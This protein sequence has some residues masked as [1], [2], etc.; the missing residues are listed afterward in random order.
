MRKIYVNFSSALVLVTSS[1]LSMGSIASSVGPASPR[2]H[3]SAKVATASVVSRQHVDARR[4]RLLDQAARSDTQTPDFET[5][6]SET[7]SVKA[8]LLQKAASSLKYPAGTSVWTSPSG[9]PA[10]S[11]NFIGQYQGSVRPDMA[12]AAGPQFVLQAVNESITLLDTSGRRQPGWPKPAQSL[13]GIPPDCTGRPAFVYDPRAFYD[14]TDSRYWV[15]IMQLEGIPGAR[16]ACP[17]V[18]QFWLAVSS[19]SDPTG[20]WNVLSFDMS[21]GTGNYADFS[22]L[23]FDGQAVY[24]SANMRNV[25]TFQYAE[26][27]EANKNAMENNQPFTALGFTRLQA[28]SVRCVMVDTV[29]PALSESQ[30]RYDPRAEFL[31]NTFNL[32][33]DPSGNDCVYSACS[34]AAVWAFS[35]PIAHDTGGSAPVLTSTLISTNPYIMPP[36]ADQPGCVRCIPTMD[37]R[38]TATPVYH[39]GLLS[40]SWST[41]INNGTQNV[42]GIAW[43]QTR[44]SLTDGSCSGSSVCPAID[45]SSTLMQQ[46]GYYFYSGDGAAYYSALMPDVGGNLFMVFDFSS[47]AFPPGVATVSR[48]ATFA[49]GAFHDGGTYLKAGAAPSR[50]A[51]WGDFN[52]ASYDGPSGDA[53]WVSGQYALSSGGWASWIGR[54]QLTLASP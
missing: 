30:A 33:G 51:Y 21:A 46:S 3:S 26:V 22:Q 31:V 27:F 39:D 2:F 25:A 28:C 19:T 42:P 18:S 35:N 54:L 52:G 11:P 37:T 32:L 7:P 47:N 36:D 48:R 15:G 4:V 49:T 10:Q 53:I 1:L 8:N 16:G 24:F 14:P 50:L 44:V 23:G 41:G 38:I 45:G 12:L 34:S 20:L 40:Y 17:F 43:G 9:G 5:P 13:F 6:D 29:Q